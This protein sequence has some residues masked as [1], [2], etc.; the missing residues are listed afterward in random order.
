MS[1]FCAGGEDENVSLLR[2]FLVNRLMKF[3]MS[4]NNFQERLGGAV[5]C[6]L[7]S[8]MFRKE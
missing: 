7:A 2:K 4:V 8:V 1:P 3:Q 6:G 5:A